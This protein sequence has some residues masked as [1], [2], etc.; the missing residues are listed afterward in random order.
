MIRVVVFL[1]SIL[2]GAP[3]HAETVQRLGRDRWSPSLVDLSKGEPGWGE[4]R[5]E[6]SAPVTYGGNAL[7]RDSYWGAPRLQ[8]VNGY[9]RK[10]ETYVAPYMRSIPRR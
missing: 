8:F 4:P 9:L 3:A 2:M 5:R 10:D 1:C 7:L 6:S